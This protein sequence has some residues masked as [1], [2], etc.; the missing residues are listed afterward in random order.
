MLA[1]A[2]VATPL[3]A[4]GS[5]AEPEDER[6][7]GA[8]A[9]ALASVSAAESPGS[10]GFGWAEPRLVAGLDRAGPE[11]VEGAL[12]PNAET[13]VSGAPAL[14]RRL[15]FDPATATRL[16]SVG[17]SY[18]FGLRLDGVD[19]RPLARALVR[20]GAEV[21]GRRDGDLL[22]VDAA[23]YAV[24]PDPLLAAGVNGLGAL[25]ALGPDESVLAISETARETLLGGDGSLLEDPTYAAAADCLGDVA[26]VR[27]VPDKLLLSVELGVDLVAV[28]VGG[29]GEVVCVL[30]G[31]QDRAGE[32]AEALRAGLDPG[33]RDPRTGKPLAERVESVEVTAGSFEGVESVRASIEP[34]AGSEPGCVFEALSSGALATLI[35]A[36]EVH[37][38]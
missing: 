26:A 11:L 23:P 22:L 35:A 36:G 3:V 16:I 18:A 8:L 7:T 33:A 4:C 38:P 10:T 5:S 6:P 31:D 29:G 27:M 9:D 12:G 28:G 21:T 34:A 19:G 30:G 2:A 14:R 20:R 1:A 24:V 13:V 25:D 15:G 32:V 17:G 37:A